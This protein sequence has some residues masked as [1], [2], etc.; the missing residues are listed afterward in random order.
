MKDGAR[1]R[2][3]PILTGNRKIRASSIDVA[4]MPHLSDAITSLDEL[5]G[6][7]EAGDSPEDIVAECKRAI[8]EWY[9][10]MLI[11]SVFSWLSTPP[12]GW[13]LLD[14]STHAEV[15]YPEL[16]AV[17]DDSLKNGSNFTLPDTENA[18][19]FSVLAKADAGAVAGENTIN[20]TVGQLPPHTHDYVPPVP[21]ADIGGAGPPMPSVA[22]G[23]AIPTTSTGDGDNIDK[24][25]L[26]YGLVFA[27]YAGR[28]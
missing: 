26:R 9:S 1:A 4:L 13:L 24:R 25:P 21:S 18:F 16:F 6:W 23:G 15:D 22:A 11:G 14:G 7:Y 3:T 2:H 17:L 10:D 8:E 12:D 19:P 5:F 27:V 20:L 28:T